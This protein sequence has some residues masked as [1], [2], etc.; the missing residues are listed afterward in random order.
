MFPQENPPVVNALNYAV[1]GRAESLDIGNVGCHLPLDKNPGSADRGWK[2]DWDASPE[3]CA[4]N[5]NDTE[6]T[7]K[8]AIQ[9]FTVRSFF[10]RIVCRST[11]RHEF[12]RFPRQRSFSYEP[13][14]RLN[15]WTPPDT[16]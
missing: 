8:N 13:T 4:N 11:S 2:L 14:K 12:A 16:A 9:H 1:R 15:G 6:K 7:G 10:F 3:F 5:R